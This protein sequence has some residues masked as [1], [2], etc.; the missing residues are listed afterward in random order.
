MH[1][2]MSYMTRAFLTSAA[3]IESHQLPEMIYLPTPNKFDN[4]VA[5][6]DNPSF[7]MRKKLWKLS[8]KRRFFNIDIHTIHK[9]FKKQYF[10]LF[11]RIQTPC[12]YANKFWP[13][14]TSFQIIFH[15]NVDRFRLLSDDAAVD[16]DKKLTIGKCCR[17][18]E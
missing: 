10:R 2:Y 7:T 6:A 9:R 1:G 18:Y 15:A 5:D 12:L 4:L 14:S 13:P 17:M 3:W 11:F 8:T 16:R